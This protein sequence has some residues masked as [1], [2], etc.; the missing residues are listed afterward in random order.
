M[1]AQI[2]AASRR[3]PQSLMARGRPMPRH[4]VL[5]IDIKGIV[6]PQLEV[7]L[8]PDVIRR[9]NAQP[10]LTIDIVSGSGEGQTVLSAFDAALFASG[11]Q[12]FNLIP[13]SSVIP[14]GAT[15][16]PRDRF[17]A[18]PSGYGNRLYVVKAEMRAETAGTAIAAGLGWFQ[19]A[20]GRGVFVEHEMSGDGWTRIEVERRLRQQIMASLADLARTRNLDD[21]MLQ[22]HV[23]I[24]SAVVAR[25]P[26]CVVALA[27]Y[28]AEPWRAAGDSVSDLGMG[29]PGWSSTDLPYAC[30]KDM[31]RTLGFR[32]AIRQIVQPHDIVVDAGAGTGI[33]S[34][35]AAEQGARV[36]ALEL[37]ALLVSSLRLSAAL[38]ELDDRI[39]VIGGDARLADVPRDVDVVIAEMIETGLIEEGQVAVLNAFH[40]R[41]VIGPRTRVI[42]SRYQTCMELVEV[43]ATF[44][45]F[46]IASPLHE[47][48]NYQRHEDGWLPVAARALTGRI[49]IN[50]LDF[51]RP[52]EPKVDRRLTFP[53]VA[54]GL[55]NAVRL[56]G[57]TR[58][59]PGRVL[60]ATNALSGDKIL[61]LPEPIPVRAGEPC[62]GRVTYTMGAG[63]GSFRWDREG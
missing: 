30:L 22:M 59:M 38:N 49:A 45:G 40:E 62:S 5:W 60:G 7:T 25:Q 11:V 52:I 37:D 24:A 4:F 34:F 39:S 63:L 27:I 20:D 43:D 55:A 31:K 26:A 44:Y 21:A 13:L 19:L 9:E 10:T 42:P 15:I 16:V 14:P 46:T 35:F 1:V 8:R 58:L 41:G 23:H 48:P 53:G 51:E 32:E 33:L 61:R 2:A 54:D 56:S 12:D 18:A 3:T 36:Y 6:M 17:V 47:W 57:E 29:D 50:D 28:A